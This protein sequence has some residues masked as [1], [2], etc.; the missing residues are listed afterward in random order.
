MAL[1]LAGCSSAGSQPEGG[2]SGPSASVAPPA[3]I[4]DGTLT[5]CTGDSP[6]NIFYD[7]N[8]EL[9]GVEIDIANALAKQLGITTK[10]EEY[11][12]SGLIPALQ[13]K[14]CDV[15]MGSLYI[16]PE[17]EEIANFVPYL[18]SGTGVGVAK[19]NRKKFTGL[20]DSLCGTKAIAIT[21]ATGGGAAEELSAK[22]EADGEKPLDITLVD[23]AASA[24]Q[25]V[26]AGQVDV[27]V[28]TSEIMSF[29]EK[30]SNG[31]FVMTGDPVGKIR[32]GAATLKA[33]AD[34]NSALDKAF[35]KLIDDGTYRSILEKWGVQ[36][37]D[38]TQP[39]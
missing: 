2:G 19:E 23:D 15:I 14:Q 21:G 22:C 39:E 26:L 6:P 17:R 20:D 27:F 18:Y 34:L 35:Q 29:Y 4:K 8:N 9:Q 11:N 10:L 28:D 12:F 38:V 7:E 5:V 13:A 16:K 30:Q 36:S 32:I 24:V 33:N 37:N 25:Q 31:A 1:A 3:I